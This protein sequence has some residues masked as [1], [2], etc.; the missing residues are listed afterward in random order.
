M[1][2]SRG[3]VHQVDGTV[4]VVSTVLAAATL[5]L[6]WYLYEY[7]ALMFERFCAED[8]V[9]ESMSFVAWLAAGLLCAG[10]IRGAPPPARPTLI[11]LAVGSLA[12]RPPVARVRGREP[13]CSS[14]PWCRCWRGR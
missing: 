11:A 13:C 5:S 14:S 2:A 7:H 3:G 9:A 1:V 8:G 4:L 10:A 6:S 12:R